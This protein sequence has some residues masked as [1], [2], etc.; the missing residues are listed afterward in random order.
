[1]KLTKR[2][3]EILELIVIEELSSSEIATLLNISIGTVDTHRKKLLQKFGVTNSV[4]L[5]KKAIVT[6]IIKV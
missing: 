2:E 5:T 6:G 4:G 1:M 3:K